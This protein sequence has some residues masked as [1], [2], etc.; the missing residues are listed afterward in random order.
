M[1][2]GVLVL[3]KATLSKLFQKHLKGKSASQDLL[4]N[5]LLEN[6]HPIKFQ[7]I[8]NEMIRKAAMKT[9]RG[10][11]PSG[12]AADSWRRILVSNNFGTPSSDLRKTFA[13]VVQNVCTVL[14]ETHTIEVF[15]SCCLINPLEFAKF[16]EEL[17][18]KVLFRL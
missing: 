17:L 16:H 1:K 18:V 12:M 7:T 2:N 13:N 4:L 9:K 11:C 10:S 5:G 8:D 3:N 14:V 15:L 6:T